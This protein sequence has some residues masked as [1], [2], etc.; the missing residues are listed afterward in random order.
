MTESAEAA[1][2]LVHYDVV[3]GI[4]TI[5]LDSPKNHNALS[6]QL[7]TELIAHFERATAETSVRAVLL[8]HTGPTFCAGADLSEARSQGVEE[9]AKELAALLRK[10]LVLPIP[11]IARIDGKARAGGLGI[12]GACDIVVASTESSFAFTEVRIG[13]APAVITLTTVPRM[14]SRTLSR[15]YLT[16]ETF[17]APAAKDSGFIT[18]FGDDVDAVLAPIVAAVRLGSPQGLR[19]SKRISN[20]KTLSDFDAGAA[21]MTALS[22]RLFGTD[23]AKEGMTSFLERRRPRWLADV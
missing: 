22:A 11:V 19:E 1:A 2:E 10:F 13:L 5:T 21:E 23:E 8:T 9:G 16:G 20:A 15:Y 14:T 3:D 7:M 12:L 18:D 6:K 17:A 4:A